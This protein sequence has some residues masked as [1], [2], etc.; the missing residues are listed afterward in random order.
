MKKRWG[1]VFMLALVFVM[2]AG[3]AWSRPRRDRVERAEPVA[4]TPAV[5]SKALSDPPPSP[6]TTT[7]SCELD[8][9]TDLVE[10]KLFFD[11]PDDLLLAMVGTFEFDPSYT[12]IPNPRLVWCVDP[13]VAIFDFEPFSET[14]Y[15][16]RFYSTHDPDLLPDY[17]NDEEDWKEINYILNQDYS[18]VVIDGRSVTWGDIQVAV[19]IF[20]TDGTIGFDFTVE[21]LDYDEAAVNYILD[22]VEAN[23]GSFVPGC[24][25]KV[26][27]LVDP[28]FELYRGETLAINQDEPTW[29]DGA[30]RQLTCIVVDNP[31]ACL[32]DRVWHDLDA[33]GIQD[34]GGAL[35][36]PP[37]QRGGTRRRPRPSRALRTGGNVW[38]S[39][40][41]RTVDAPDTGI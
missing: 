39:N 7:E 8:L 2:V 13:E 27:V 36:G 40:P 6:P 11:W 41:P 29:P 3:T 4:S 16:V 14:S 15:L 35:H 28:I 1:T 31:C 32:G 18:S 19:W 10:M 17:A 26:V 12:A 33:D 20:S 22:D 37:A 30:A 24:G 25:G 38:E 21:D 23:I 34:D 9:P 5:L